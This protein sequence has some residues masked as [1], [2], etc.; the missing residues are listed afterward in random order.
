[1]PKQIIWL[2]GMNLRAVSL[3]PRIYH[4]ST[5]SLAPVHDLIASYVGIIAFQNRSLSQCTVRG[6][7]VFPDKSM[8]RDGWA[9]ETSQ[10]QQ[11]ARK[12]TE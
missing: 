12:F 11:W 4:I 3:F 7:N 1:M 8:S 10:G 2:H 6:V 5:S 9:M